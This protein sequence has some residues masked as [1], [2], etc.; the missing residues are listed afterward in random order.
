MKRYVTEKIRKTVEYNYRQVR[1]DFDSKKVSFASK[2]KELK[3]A[4]DE[5]D[6][7]NCVDMTELE[8]L[9]K[10]MELD[11]DGDWNDKV[12][13]FLHEALAQ[14]PMPRSVEL[15]SSVSHATEEQSDEI[16]LPPRKRRQI[17]FSDVKVL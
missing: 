3:L 13:E 6:A 2:L 17:D 1:G 15:L 8:D 16:S 12:T 14:C 5:I 7:R 10:R 11:E 9:Y 4:N